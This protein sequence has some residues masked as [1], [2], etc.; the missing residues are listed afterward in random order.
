MHGGTDT[1]EGLEIDGPEGST[2]TDGMFTLK[3]GS[4]MSVGGAKPGSPAD[5]KSKAQ[6]TI[7]NVIFSNYVTDAD[8][9]KIRSSYDDANS[10]AIKTDA[11]THL[12]DVNA[13]LKL[14]TSNFVGV[15]VYTK[16]DAC[17]VLVGEQLSA[18][19]AAVSTT[20]AVGADKSTFD[21]WTLASIAGLLN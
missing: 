12:T 19:A 11:Y 10:C 16:Y 5:I 21:N 14:V 1:D 13:T 7:D 9:I 2:Y 20:D 18:E 3:N 15:E 6:G 17:S 4:V 8:A